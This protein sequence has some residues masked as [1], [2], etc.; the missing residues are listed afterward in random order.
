MNSN[1]K[2]FP[3]EEEKS[4]GDPHLVLWSQLLARSKG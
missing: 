2:A 4:Q 1:I 3:V